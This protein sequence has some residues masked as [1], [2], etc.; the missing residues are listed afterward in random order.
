MKKSLLIFA[1]VMILPQMTLAA[2]PSS[3]LYRE[4]TQKEQR[5]IRLINRAGQISNERFS[6]EEDK[7][8]AQYA[9]N[10][11]IANFQNIK[12]EISNFEQ[13]E[14]TPNDQTLTQASLRLDKLIKE[15]QNYLK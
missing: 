7:F 13:K 5:A 11:F 1:L 9:F 4:V 8:N 3:D 12:E 15:L 10:G 6:N 2:I 14:L